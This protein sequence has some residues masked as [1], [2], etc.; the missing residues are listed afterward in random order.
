M[1][2]L[3]ANPHIS[4]DKL[5]EKTG[6]SRATVKRMIKR[7]KQASYISRIGS[8]KTGYWEINAQCH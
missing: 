2:L 6:R 5:V 1:A 4:Y 7:L 3:K 8:D